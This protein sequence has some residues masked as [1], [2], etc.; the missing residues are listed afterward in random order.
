[1]GN[2]RTLKGQHTQIH[3]ILA[4]TCASTGPLLMSNFDMSE[5]D[6][7]KYRSISERN[8]LILKKTY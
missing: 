4:S 1:M 6:N 2:N 3:I 5:I 8:H 7:N